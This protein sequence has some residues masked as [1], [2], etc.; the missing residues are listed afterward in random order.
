MHHWITLRWRI[1]RDT[2]DE[3]QIKEESI[4]ESIVNVY[5]DPDSGSDIERNYFSTT[6]LI[7]DQEK[8]KDW[9]RD[10]TWNFTGTS[11]FPISLLIFSFFVESA[12]LTMQWSLFCVGVWTVT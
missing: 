9:A 4:K 2:V 11:E 5:K 1:R 6:L 8:R 10:L 3:Y 12:L 7:F